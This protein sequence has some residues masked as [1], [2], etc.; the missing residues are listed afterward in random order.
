M[1]LN[2][3]SGALLGVGGF[4]F[5]R[6]GKGKGKCAAAAMAEAAAVAVVAGTQDSSK[7][8]ALETGC[9]DLYDVMH[10]FII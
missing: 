7:G 1:F 3:L 10:S 2:W 4:Q 9:S 8:G 6:L 5:H